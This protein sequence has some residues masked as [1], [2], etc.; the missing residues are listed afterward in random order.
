[1]SSRRVAFRKD[2]LRAPLTLP[3]DAAFRA[4][5]IHSDVQR[6]FE[7]MAMLQVIVLAFS[8]KHNIRMRFQLSH[9]VSR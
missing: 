4:A 5:P 3:R 1:M 2:F 9:S 8:Y 7:N 6:I